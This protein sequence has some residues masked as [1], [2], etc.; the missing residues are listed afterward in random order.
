LKAVVE[1]L[2]SFNGKV[3]I[4]T[5]FLRGNFK[6]EIIDNTTDAEIAEWLKLVAEIK[7]LQVMI[8]TVD[9][10]TPAAGLEKVKLNDLEKIALRARA[11]GFEVQV[12]G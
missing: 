5:L 6:G 7:P 3:I 12:S 4:Q 10:D 11:I 8:Y 1:N 9:R 2:K